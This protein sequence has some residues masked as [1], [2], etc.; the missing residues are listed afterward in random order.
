MPHLVALGFEVALEG[1]FGGDGGGDT[2]DDGDACG[3]ERGDLLGIVGDE[4]DA[5]DA[6]LAKDGGGEFELAVVGA[7]AE[8]FVGFDG[9]E[10]LVLQFVGAEL[11]HEADAAALLLFVEQDA[12]ALTGDEAEREVELVMAVAAEGVEDVSG[13]ALGVDADQRRGFGVE[14]AH[15]E[16][17]GVFDLAAVGV[18]VEVARLGEAFKAEDAEVSPAGGEVGIGDLA[19]GNERHNN[20]ID[21][22][23]GGKIH[24]ARWAKGK[25]LDA[26]CAEGA[27]FREGRR[28]QS[29]T[30]RVEACTGTTPNSS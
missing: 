1:G 23:E 7:E 11:G 14:V 18:G 17:D 20:I 5:V 21:S 2:L 10:T 13:E 9:V 3:F 28:R 27:K 30:R 6:E 12:G 22:R 15:G 26:E 25:G 16:R 24:A 8:A 29:A 19:N 4:A